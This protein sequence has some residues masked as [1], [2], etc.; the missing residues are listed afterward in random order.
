MDLDGKTTLVT[1]GAA[2]V[3]AGT[4][5]GS[6]TPVRSAEM[7]FAVVRA[8][9]WTGPQ[10]DVRSGSPGSCQGAAGIEP[11]VVTRIGVSCVVG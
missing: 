10:P 5:G 7:S 2:G 1:G 9:G 11:R 6:R 3:G 8:E 4:G